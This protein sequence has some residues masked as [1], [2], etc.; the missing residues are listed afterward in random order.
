MGFFGTGSCKS[1][2]SGQERIPVDWQVHGGYDC[3]HQRQHWHWSDCYW[4]LF[5]VKCFVRKLA[6]TYPPVTRV[7]PYLCS[8]VRVYVGSAIPYPDPYPPN[9]YLCTH[10]VSKTLARHYEWPGDCSQA[11]SLE[12]CS[13]PSRGLDSLDFDRWMLLTLAFGDHIQSAQNHT[14]HAQQTKNWNSLNFKCSSSPF[15]LIFHIWSHVVYYY[16]V[17]SFASGGL[18]TPTAFP[19]GLRA[20]S[21]GL[22]VSRIHI[23]LLFHH[24]IFPMIFRCLSGHFW[25]DHKV[26]QTFLTDFWWTKSKPIPIVHWKCLT[27]TNGIPAEVRWNSNGLLQWLLYNIK[28]L[29]RRWI[30]HLNSAAQLDYTTQVLNQLHRRGFNM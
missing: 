13:W 15:C 8:W 11:L 9:P 27:S 5:V 28:K 7:Y 10:G 22:R 29:Q 30:E 19:G 12:A 26:Q 21:V 25:L 18:Y 24:S 4:S 20:D 16:H 14:C 23:F 3:S 17:P 1:W 6:Q 2:S